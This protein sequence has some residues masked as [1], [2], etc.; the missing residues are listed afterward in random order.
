MRYQEEMCGCDSVCQFKKILDHFHSKPSYRVPIELNI[1]WQERLTTCIDEVDKYNHNSW[2]F[3]KAFWIVNVNLN[4]KQFHAGD[5]KKEG[6]T[7]KFE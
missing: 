1:L 2:K 3:P 4:R 5:S 7:F 6:V